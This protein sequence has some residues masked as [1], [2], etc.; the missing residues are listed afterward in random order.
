MISRFRKEGFRGTL[1]FML[2][3]LVILMPIKTACAAEMRSV[4]EAKNGVVEIQTGIVV[5]NGRFYPVKCTSGFLV[6]NTSGSVYIITANHNMSLSKR[7]KRQ[8]CRKKKIKDVSVTEI[9]S[10][11][12][13]K[14]DVTAEMSVIAASKKEDFCILSAGDV[15]Q[16]KKAL[17]LGSRGDIEIGDAVFAVGF[18]LGAEVSGKFSA[19]EMEIYSGFVQN[20]A[21]KIKKQEY[22]QYSA[23]ITSGNFGSVLLSTEGYAVGMNH[24]S[25]RNKSSKEYYALP[26]DAVRNIL[27]NYGIFYDSKE[28]DKAYFSLQ[29]KYKKCL[30]SIESGKYK[31][32]SLISLE[33]AVQL[34]ENILGEKHSSLSEIRAAMRTLDIAERQMVSKVSKVW[35]VEILLGIAILILLIH[36]VYLLMMHRKIKARNNII[37]SENVQNDVFFET[38]YQYSDFP[39]KTSLKKHDRTDDGIL[40]EYEKEGTV[41]LHS[42]NGCFTSRNNT[43]SERKAWLIRKKTG[44]DIIIN[45][46]DFRIGKNNK[47]VDFVIDDNKAVS[48]EHAEIRCLSGKYYIYDMDSANGTFVNGK[49]VDGSGIELSNH[50]TVVLADEQFEFVKEV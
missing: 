10:R 9:S 29:G 43:V 28:R 40:S 30:S 15:L 4:E 44:Q 12:I 27:D 13:V 2:S 25:V 49:Q 11:L 24:S 6:S 50:D 7:E 33:E 47:V 23:A 16:E 14:G 17:P 32:K 20:T 45:K 5:S 37:L 48:R 35:I 18:S 21:A 46:N 26:I 3:L 22:I 41:L 8:F 1:L 38:D 42:G 31:P 19:E 39:E 34:A 36:F